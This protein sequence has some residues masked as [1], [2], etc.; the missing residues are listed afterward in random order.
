MDLMMKEKVKLL[1]IVAPTKLECHA[2]AKEFSLDFLKVDRMRFISNPYHLRGWSRGTPFIALN[3]SVWPELL[4][5]ALDALT[6]SGQLRIA[7]DRDL[8]ELVDDFSANVPAQR[9]RFATGARM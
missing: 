5:K 1:L 7:N 6:M 2:T 8:S 4:D 3:R 9:A